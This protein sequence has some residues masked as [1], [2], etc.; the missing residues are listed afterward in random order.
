MISNFRITCENP[1]LFKG[2]IYKSQQLGFYGR[3]LYVRLLYFNYLIITKNMLYYMYNEK[4]L[5]TR[6]NLRI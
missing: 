6:K 2:E 1:L 5:K 3:Q 4:Q